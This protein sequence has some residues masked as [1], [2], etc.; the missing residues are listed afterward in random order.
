MIWWVYILECSDSTLYTGI[1]NNLSRR[2]N[3]H[4]AGKGSKYTRGRT[5]VKLKNAWSYSTRGIASKVEYAIKK[6]TREEKLILCAK[7]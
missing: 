5:P 3:E 2:L 1:T 4:K 6:L 7:P